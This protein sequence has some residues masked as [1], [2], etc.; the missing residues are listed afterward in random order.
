[1][2]TAEKQL[3]VWKP[4]KVGQRIKVTA[5][6]RNGQLGTVKERLDDFINGMGRYGVALDSCPDLT[7]DFCRHE[8]TKVKDK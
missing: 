4:L 7:T 2:T 8:L 1:M 5:R 6:Y 3:S